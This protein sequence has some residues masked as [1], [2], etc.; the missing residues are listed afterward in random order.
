MLVYLPI[1]RLKNH[2]R[3]PRKITAEAMEKLCV[4]MKLDPDFLERRPVLCY[5]DE[6]G[7]DYIV[8]AGNQRLRAAKKL[9]WSE[10]AC[11]VD[12]YP[13]LGTIKRRIII[14]NKSSGDWDYDI[15]SADYEVEELFDLGFNEKDLFGKEEEKEKTIPVKLKATVTFDD[16]DQMDDLTPKL[17]DFCETHGLK[18]TIGK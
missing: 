12:E 3:N 13:D 15:L 11:I 2:E 16:A 7:K 6:K 5:L 1:K 8:Y 17:E 9:G 18:L 4:N 10:I 14:D